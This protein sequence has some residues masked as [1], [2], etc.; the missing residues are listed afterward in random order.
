MTELRGMT[1]EASRRGYSF[2]VVRK[3]IPNRPAYVTS[4][5]G[6]PA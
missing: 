1:R 3:R 6:L 5:I 4:V 2:E